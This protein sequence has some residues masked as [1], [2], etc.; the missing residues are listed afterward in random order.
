MDAEAKK[1]ARGEINW[2]DR[3]DV[4]AAGSRYRGPLPQTQL[5]LDNSYLFRNIAC[6]NTEGSLKVF[7]SPEPNAHGEFIVYHYPSSV[8]VCVC[9]SVNNFKL[10][11]LG[12]QWA[13]C[14]Q[15]LSEA[16]LG[17]E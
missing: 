8:S 10:E 3:S 7:S 12:N 14:N 11:Y 2:N 16:S 17:R 9:V 1:R 4:T 5:E 6:F 13:N 15:I